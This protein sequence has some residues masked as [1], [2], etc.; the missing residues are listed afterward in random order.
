MAAKKKKKKTKKQRDAEAAGEEPEI[1]EAERNEAVAEAAEYAIRAA[2]EAKAAYKAASAIV[3]KEVRVYKALKAK[4]R[5]MN[6]NSSS[7][8]RKAARERQREGQQPEEQSTMSDLHT[9]MST[10]KQHERSR[11]G[12][13]R[14]N[15]KVRQQALRRQ[16]LLKMG[17]KAWHAHEWS[18]EFPVSTVA[19]AIPSKLGPRA[20]AINKYKQQ[21]AG[22]RNLRWAVEKKQH[23][24]DKPIPNSQE[25]EEDERVAR[26]CKLDLG[27]TEFFEV[28]GLW[29]P[30]T[31]EQCGG[32]WT[33]SRFE[34]HRAA[35]HHRQSLTPWHPTNE[36]CRLFGRCDEGIGAI[37]QEVICRQ[38]EEALERTLREW[39]KLPEVTLAQ[40]GV[41]GKVESDIGELKMLLA[42][43]KMVLERARARDIEEQNM[44][45]R[46]PTN[47]GRGTTGGGRSPNTNIHM[48]TGGCGVTYAGAEDSHGRS[49]FSPNP[50]SVTDDG[51]Q[52]SKNPHVA[53]GR[54]K[55]AS[56]TASSVRAR[57]Q[58]W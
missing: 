12:E 39:E 7:D 46:V 45:E 31:G 25:R 49:A 44:L 33:D 42:R 32:K 22:K 53:F 15:Q 51:E 3:K 21:S 5:S 38:I 24:W 55:S 13:M 9:L 28:N 50:M 2:A 26:G 37:Q 8:R 10:K 48:S 58:A 4:V 30:A 56:S 47:T 57:K 40:Q 6:A 19:G 14:R 43:N 20:T 17:Q 34:R 35:F 11:G 1:N 29:R 36:V 54:P 18:K 41:K 27:V 16:K 52:R 23:A